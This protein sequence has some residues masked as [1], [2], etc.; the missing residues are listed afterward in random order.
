MNDVQ[1]QYLLFI[2]GAYGQSIFEIICS[3]FIK[4]PEKSI[5]FLVTIILA[6]LLISDRI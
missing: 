2:L 5:A 6:Y 1:K 3:G 4:S